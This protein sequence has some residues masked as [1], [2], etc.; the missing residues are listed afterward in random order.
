MIVVRRYKK[1][2]QVYITKG[3][4]IILFNPK[5]NKIILEVILTELYDNETTQ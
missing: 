5:N 2:I 3:G 1:D 4:T